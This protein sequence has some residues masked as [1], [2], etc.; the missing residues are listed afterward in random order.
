MSSEKSEATMVIIKP[1]GIKKSLTGNVITRLSETKLQILAAK[2]M[3]ITR[4]LA[5]EHYSHLRE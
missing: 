1:D 5:E 2:M 3:T 4:E